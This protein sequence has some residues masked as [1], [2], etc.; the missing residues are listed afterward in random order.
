MC[1]HWSRMESD[2]SNDSLKCPTCEESFATKQSLGK[3]LN[4][5]NKCVPKGQPKYYCEPCER[6]F[7]R[8]DHLVVHTKTQKH[9]DAVKALAALVDASTDNSNNANHCDNSTHT[10]N[11]TN[12]HITNND[13][14]ITNNYTLANP[15]PRPRMFGRTDIE[16]TADLTF[17]ELNKHL[18]VKNGTGLLPFV[19]MFK[20]MHL[21]DEAP[22]NH[23]V[24]MEKGGVAL[25]YKQRHW[26]LV[27]DPEG[28]VRE[29]LSA[30]ATLFLDVED[31]LRENLDGITMQKFWKLRDQMEHAAIGYRNPS[32]EVLKLLD[33]MRDA[34][35][36][37]TARRTDL[38][39]YAKADLEAAPPMQAVPN[40]R[41]LPMWQPGGNRYEAFKES[42]D[43]GEE[44][45]MPP[46]HM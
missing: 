35:V 5:K 39:A 31:I 29:C 22:R 23:N 2:T 37:F 38:L 18:N 40:T 24:L 26:R 15:P 1:R 34:I 16:H 6:E 3:H 25:A 12:N 45:S 20:L 19:N 4:K 27:K 17:E 11:T 32:S 14:R 44:P 8:K 43:T 33:K 7:D 42:R 21:N 30:A 41:D 46:E 36:E 9:K 13:N 28:M 10:H